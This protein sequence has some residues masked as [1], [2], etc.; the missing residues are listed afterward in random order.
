[1][2]K[3]VLGLGLATILFA[4][5]LA[6]ANF[7]L[8]TQFAAFK[9]PLNP[10]SWKTILP[11]V[12]SALSAWLSV[13]GL[14]S[15]QLAPDDLKGIEAKV[16]D[17]RDK[18]VEARTITQGEA[19][20]TRIIVKEGNQALL[21][22]MAQ[23]EARLGPEAAKDFEATIAELLAGKDQREA[24]AEEAL[25]R[26]DI[27]GAGDFLLNLGRQEG[28]AADDFARH[29]R[30]R[31]RKAGT[32]FYGTN[33]RKAIEAYQGCLDHGSKR[34]WDYIY[35][36]RL[37]VMAGLTSEAKAVFEAGLHVDA[38][39]RDDMVLKNEIGDVA[40]AQNDLSTAKTY[41][42]DDLKIAKALAEGDPGNAEYQRDLSVSYERLGDVAVAQNDLSTAKTYYTD[43]L[44]V[45]KA[46]AEGDPGNAGYQRDLIVSYS[47][48]ASID[49][50]RALH[51]WT[52]A[53]TVS[54]RMVDAG[55]LAP[56]DVQIPNIIESEI[57]RLKTE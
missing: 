35:L 27:E 16:A 34:A 41:Y 32:L 46:L 7:D 43:G 40:R 6:S 13:K 55:Q 57:A 12:A 39:Q 5:G 11:T 1:M 31:F 17:A 2:V 8:S 50:E 21:E 24:P 36:G 33:T 28:A 56:M 26:G 45:R 15:K 48:L 38:S 30:E 51:W 22:R 53:K 29:C 20:K 3:P 54:D 23:I 18:A 49:T 25:Q 47:R 19:A 42:T 4:G 37:K 10:A 14:W 9:T 52:L 44:D